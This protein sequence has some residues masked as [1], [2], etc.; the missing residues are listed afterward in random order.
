RRAR[1][2]RR[3]AWRAARGACAAVRLVL[4]LRTRLQRP[5]CHRLIF[6]ETQ[7]SQRT[8]GM[9]GAKFGA[10][11]S[12]VLA[13]TDLFD[14]TALPKPPPTFGHYQRLGPL[15]MMMNDK[16]SCCVVAMAQHRIMYWRAAA[17]GKATF[18]D[19]V[20]V[21]NYREVSPYSPFI[22]FSDQGVDMS[23]FPDHWQ[24]V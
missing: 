3:G 17:G 8:P 11:P 2:H 7:M 10:R 16:L 4:W 23:T 22:P 24:R 15:G 14:A 5:H 19:D 20:T 13:F 9:R 21:A 12:H 18:N 1:R 6:Q